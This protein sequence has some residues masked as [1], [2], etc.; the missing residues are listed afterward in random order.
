MRICPVRTVLSMLATLLVAAAPASA[1]I[2][3]RISDGGAQEGTGRLVLDQYGTL[4][5]G[6]VAINLTDPNAWTF[7]FN[8]TT[9]VGADVGALVV[10]DPSAAGAC[11]ASDSGNG[12]PEDNLATCNLALDAAF[13][14]GS[15]PL[16][17]LGDGA[18]SSTVVI[19]PSATGVRIYGE[20][21][22]DVLTGDLGSDTI[23]GGGGNDDIDG[24]GGGDTLVGGPGTDSVY[25]DDR[26]DPA[27]GS[28][29]DTLYLRE[30]DTDF[31]FCGGGTDT[32]IADAVALEANSHFN[33]CETI[34]RPATT[35]APPVNPTPTTPVATK[36]G[37]V[38]LPD[39]RKVDTTKL[40]TWP[41]TRGYN[42]L[43][44]YLVLANQMGI[45]LNDSKS[46][47]KIVYGTKTQIEKKYG[48]SPRN[49][50]VWM[51]NDILADTIKAD[52]PL[53]IGV[54]QSVT[55][56][57]TY[58]GGP[59]KDTC[60]Q[61]AKERVD[62]PFDDFAKYMAS[63]GCK[64]DD[65]KVVLP[66]RTNNGGE[67]QLTSGDRCEATKMVRDGRAIDTT[68][69]VPSTV[70]LQDLRIS[71]VPT[72]TGISL[73][74]AGFVYPYAGTGTKAFNAGFYVVVHDRAGRPVNGVRI[75][76]DASAA[77]GNTFESPRTA[78][79]KVKDR[80]GKVRTF[81]GATV[82]DMLSPKRA[83]QVRIAAIGVG[84][85]GVALCGGGALMA[86]ALVSTVGTEM[87][88]ATGRQ[89]TL[90]QTGS[91]K[92]WTASGAEGKVA[93]RATERAIWDD[94]VKAVLGFL[95]FRTTSDQVLAGGFPAQMA[96]GQVV[97]NN[98]TAARIVASGGGNIVAGGAGNVLHQ[99]P[100]GE[101]KFGPGAAIVASGGGNLGYTLGA[102]SRI[103]AS[104]G[105]NMTNQPVGL[106]GPAIDI[107][108]SPVLQLPGAGIVAAGGGNIVAAGGGNVVAAGGGNIVASGGGNAVAVRGAAASLLA[109]DGA[110]LIGNDG[111]GLLANDGGG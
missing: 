15:Q 107:T 68:L 45:P 92:T 28:G 63:V 57:P 89:F 94:F 43:G 4:P 33:G 10:I 2:R 26:F 82:V 59:T 52:T 73:T 53:T 71:F 44:V 62:M 38:E 79:L 93:A 11:T 41:D 36:V 12:N 97:G 31:A 9:D 5:S 74:K 27:A 25:G 69:Q 50:G 77:G 14:L 81:Q 91:T 76:V 35:P 49:K 16:L 99:V 17:Y 18:T 1:E 65:V 88:T 19:D 40:F 24:A 34:D 103:V 98:L 66:P 87:T 102:A 55:F 75:F 84:S 7:S 105:G 13:T 67:K 85:N 110:G 109:N 56:N 61:D 111:S 48:K 95:G 64:I 96:L 30:N 108:R 6:S 8:S 101:A 47:P 46:K 78:S 29:N 86:R 22:N 60:I 83:G 90:K 72:D 51:E 20:L 58:W 3:V 23:D 42:V 54:G 106:I 39:A 70:D 104:G 80:T 32:V 21:G 37:S 100:A